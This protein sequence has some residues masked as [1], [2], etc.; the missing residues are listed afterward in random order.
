MSYGTKAYTIN[1]LIEE[2]SGLSVRQVSTV[3]NLA[4]AISPRAGV[5]STK[6]AVLDTFLGGGLEAIINGSYSGYNTTGS[7]ARTRVLRA[8]RNR[9]RGNL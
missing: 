5:N 4:S 3:E 6:L 9:K 7:S 1:R 2:I 8:L